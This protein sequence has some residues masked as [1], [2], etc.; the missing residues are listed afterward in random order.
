MAD[1]ATP[2]VGDYIVVSWGYD[3]TNIDF[4][5]VVSLT[6]S[7][8]SIR[9]QKV[10]PKIVNETRFS[11]ALM[12]TTNPAQRT[13]DIDGEQVTVNHDIMTKRIG[14]SSWDGKITISMDHGV[15]RLWGGTPE[16]ATHPHYGH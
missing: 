2:V 11:V 14:R 6:K 10:Q 13:V 1:H 8:K 7:G 16:Y 4:Y 5:E 12:P 15:G 9:I 3:Q